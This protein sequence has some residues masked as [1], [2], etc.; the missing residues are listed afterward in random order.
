MRFRIAT[1]SGSDGGAGDKEE[2]EEGKAPGSG[3]GAPT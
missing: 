3:V 1:S 2:V